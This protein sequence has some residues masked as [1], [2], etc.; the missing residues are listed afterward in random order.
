[1]ALSTRRDFLKQIGWAGVGA[2]TS[3]PLAALAA[4]GGGDE[5]KPNVLFLAVDDLRP[6]LNCYGRTQM[7]TPNFDALA[8]QS[9]VFTRAYCQVPVCGASRASLL[10]GLRPTPTRFRNYYSSKKEAPNVDSL[11]MTFK[12]NG[13]TTLTRGKIYHHGSDD[14]PAWDDRWRASNARAYQTPKAQGQQAR[15]KGKFK[16]G[17]PFEAADVAD[18]K[19]P[20]GKLANKLIG[21]LKTLAAGDKPWFLAGGFLKP[22]LP[23]TCPKKYW[24]LYDRKK[25]DL[26][27]NPFRPKGAP[28]AAMHN[29]GELRGYVGVPKKG[30]VSDEM[31][32]DLIHGYYACVS[33]VDAQ[34]GRVMAELDK[35]GLRDN[36]IVVLWGDHGWQLGDHGLWCKHSNFETSLH[37]PLLISAPGDKPG[38]CNAL[39][40]FVDIYPTLC[41]LAGIKQPSHLQGSS[42]VPLLKNPKRKWKPAVFSRYS[43]G[44]T[45]KTNRFRYT[46]WK[47]NAGKVR[48][49]M[50]YDH[51]RDPNE[52]VNI[53]TDPRYAAQ[54]RTMQSWLAK[55]YK[56]ARPRK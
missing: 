42:M 14:G 37:S 36:T 7:I 55:G 43:G 40:E 51:Q 49:K 23:F 18:D 32:R 28:Q 3:G 9:M 25:I 1:M 8:K 5:P 44:A 39:V 27:D 38:R 54:V 11:P 6:Q 20:D 22:H 4:Q 2:I 52:N 17:P 41:Q 10:T 30:P 33:F 34:L 48:A 50:L 26:E 53:A 46:Q 16:N 19:Y 29:W 45:V 15:S 21:D 35:L 12:R 31:A 56:S 47:N 24:D 13:Y